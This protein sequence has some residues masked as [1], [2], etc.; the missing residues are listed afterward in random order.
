MTTHKI[1]TKD[2]Q[3][4]VYCEKSM[5]YIDAKKCEKCKYFK[6]IDPVKAQILCKY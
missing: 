2:D 1:I 4:R 5:S 3:F 6:S